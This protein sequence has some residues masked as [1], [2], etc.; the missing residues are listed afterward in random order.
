MLIR[1]M[2]EK[3]G[4]S[5]E[6]ELGVEIVS[7]LYGE[8]EGD[9]K[10]AFEQHM[11]GCSSCMAEFA[12]FSSVTSSFSE[13]KAAAFD[14]L[15]TPAI[16]IAYDTPVAPEGIF[17]RFAKFFSFAP[18]PPVAKGFAAIA[19]LVVLG[20][21]AFNWP[22]EEVSV[23]DTHAPSYT[24]SSPSVPA[25]ASSVEVVKENDPAPVVPAEKQLSDSARELPVTNARVIKPAETRGTS[26]VPQPKP[27]AIDTP[28]AKR[29]VSKPV[30][31]V[32]SLN[33]YA[34]NVD[35]TLR[36]TDLFEEIDTRE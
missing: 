26:K 22:K 15:Q 6:C 18:W 2:F 16:E 35:N 11:T 20:L 33:E 36:L 13:W 32:P 19:I 14:H 23:A 28:A 30:Q 8:I 24:N 29:E 10:R 3:D 7:Y 34:E 31:K 21:I 27:A 5:G 12:S 17:S 4:R 9:E 25:P 1:D